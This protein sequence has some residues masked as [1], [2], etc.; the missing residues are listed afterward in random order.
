MDKQVD[1]STEFASKM[2]ALQIAYAHMRIPGINSKRKTNNISQND[3][4]NERANTMDKQVD[5]STELASKMNAFQEEFEF[6]PCRL[7]EQQDRKRRVFSDLTNYNDSEYLMP[8][9]K[10]TVTPMM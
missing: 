8:V 2:K 5:L 6:N 10:K 7:V 3:S 9:A 4:L 1:L